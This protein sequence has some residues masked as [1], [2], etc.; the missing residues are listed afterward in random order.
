MEKRTI[1]VI[2]DEAYMRKIIS[3]ILKTEGYIVVESE[4]GK[5]GLDKVR[6]SSPSCVLLDIKLPDIDGVEILKKIKRMNQSIPVIMLTAYGNISS[7]VQTVKL[8]AYD[9]LQKPFDN[10]ELKVVIKRAVEN[11]HLYNEILRLKSALGE[12]IDI[13][14][15][16]G[17]SPAIRRVLQMVNLVAPT[18]ATVF[19]QGKTGTGK[20]LIAHLI[21]QKSP[22]A[23]KPFVAIDCGAIPKDLFESELFGHEKGAFTGADA[24]RIGKLEQAS[25][26]TL[27]LDEINN[28][29]LQL[30]PKLLRA[31]Q[32]KEIQRLGSSKTISVDIRLI[33]ASSVDIVEKVKTGDF[34]EELLYRL[35]EFKIS[36]PTLSQRRDDIPTLANY[37]LQEAK[38]E[39]QKNLTGF[40]QK[41]L[42]ILLHYNWPGNI[43]ELKNVI[44]SAVI[45]AQNEYIS[46]EDLI[47]IPIEDNVQSS[48][49]LQV[50]DKEQSNQ[51]DTPLSKKVKNYEV[52]VIKHA[53]EKT[54]GN[55]T[56]T[57][58]MLGISR[59]TLYRKMKELDL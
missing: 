24:I 27:F 57:A 7:A 20:E 56:K 32:E 10:E 37:F 6:E 21:H 49:Y 3:K 36:L 25:G 11:Y 48:E 22:R 38:E 46:K 47:F 52:D 51:S 43:R 30:Q 41:A 17:E 29:P 54:N 5:E 18:N 28:L 31:I 40:T 44:R 50:V 33:V 55:K 13:K 4:R 23:N 1:L 8:G 26:G 39:M 53:L 35:Y 12:S 15:M 45:L 19:L 14:K 59:A 9:Y 34:R 58:E 42:D 16:M 2:D